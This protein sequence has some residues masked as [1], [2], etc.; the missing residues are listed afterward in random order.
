[1]S[2][3]LKKELYLHF[4]IKSWDWYFQKIPEQKLKRK[5]LNKSR[6]FGITY[7]ELN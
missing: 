4:S 6:Y 2:V 3:P 7:L 5:T 1:M